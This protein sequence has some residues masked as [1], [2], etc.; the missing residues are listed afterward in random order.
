MYSEIK[1]AIKQAYFSKI[2]LYITVLT[3][4]KN[5][6]L[7][8][9]VMLLDN[10]RVLFIIFVHFLVN[11]VAFRSLREI[12]KSNTVDPIGNYDINLTSCD[13]IS[14]PCRSQRR[15]SWTK[16]L[17]ILLTLSVSFSLLYCYR[18][19]LEACPTTAT[20]DQRRPGLDRVKVVS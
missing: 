2:I 6:F 5:D 14:I 15:H 20:E 16:F 7:T 19:L 1:K 17:D 13:V 3:E 4:N 8:E 9:G 10:F 18:S 11:W 12:T